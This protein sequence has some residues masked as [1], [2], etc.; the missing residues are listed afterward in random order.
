MSD[1]I[2]INKCSY[3]TLLDLPGVG[4]K[5][6]DL[7]LQQR[8]IL[9]SITAETIRNIP[10]LQVTQELLDKLDFEPY[11]G[12]PNDDRSK[13]R[14]LDEGR[15]PLVLGA[16]A[17]ATVPSQENIINK[18]SAAIASASLAGPPLSYSNPMGAGAVPKMTSQL[19]PGIDPNPWQ[20]SNT[21]QQPGTSYVTP[22]GGFASIQHPPGPINL[23]SGVSA[24]YQQYPAINSVKQEPWTVTSQTHYISPQSMIG[25]GNTISTNQFN[26][27]AQMGYGQ[28]VV[29]N[30]TQGTFYDSNKPAYP[31][32]PTYLNQPSYQNLQQPQGQFPSSAAGVVERQNYSNDFRRPFNIPKSL[33]YDGTSNW[34]A[35][36]AK[37]ARYAEAQGWTAKTCKDYLCWCL[38]GKASEFYTLLIERDPNMEYF[39]LMRKLEKR[40]GFKDLPETAQVQFMQ[41]K[42]TPDEKLEEWADRV[43]SLATRAF[44]NL[45]DEHMYQQ[46]IMRLCQGANDKD[47]G[48]Y[49]ANL[50]PKTMEDA[51]DRFR[52]YQHNNAAIFGRQSRRDIRYIAEEESEEKQS[53]TIQA[54]SPAN[55][56]I[57]MNTRLSSLEQKVTDL[58]S[59]MSALM[60]DV[61]KLIETQPYRRRTNS[62][63]PSRGEC[64]HCGSK[65]HFK[66]DCPAR[67][68][69]NRVAKEEKKVSFSD[70]KYLNENGSGNQA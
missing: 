23:Q 30:N 50:R 45:P 21:L 55:Q 14:D 13:E 56:S 70:T 3:R 58:T 61:R 48:Q 57:S 69:E 42:Q 52:W 63:S 1:K 19:Q 46:A 68:P 38:E 47:A 18:V 67:N 32:Q 36:K 39:D 33:L 65:G 41:A 34:Q 37:F 35:F 53:V 5:I 59:N 7:I 6:A 9:G 10:R 54:T 20:V 60:T 49:A 24:G 51:L 8:D 44:K 43:L 4:R 15:E 40:F 31:Q 16:G 27:H 62:H 66:R 29:G 2:K 11:E 26:P 64:Y 25:Y 28:N 12:D 17:A 22:Q